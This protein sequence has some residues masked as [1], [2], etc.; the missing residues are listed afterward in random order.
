MTEFETKSL[1]IATDSLAVAKGQ[2]YSYV[3]ADVIAVLALIAA[4]IGG[5]LAYRNVKIMRGN[6]QLF[7]EQDMAARRKLFHDVAG[8]MNKPGAEKE[9]LTLLR[10]EEAK[11]SYLN[12][13]ERLASFVLGGYFPE[14]D[15][16]RDYHEAIR[17]VIRELNDDFRTGTHYRNIV[18]LH[19]RW[20]DR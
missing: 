7:L 13:L 19:D 4:V 6:M 8:E 16:R 14:D 5:W 18:K 9:G 17:G 10:Y 12:A 2:L 1:A 15:M 11:E 20:Q 3:A